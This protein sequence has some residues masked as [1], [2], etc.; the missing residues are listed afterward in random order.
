MKQKAFLCSAVPATR[1]IFARHSLKAEFLSAEAGEAAFI[2]KAARHIRQDVF[3][4]YPYCRFGKQDEL[5]KRL[6]ER[7][8][9]PQQISEALAKAWLHERDE[10]LLPVK[11][12]WR[13]RVLSADGLSIMLAIVLSWVTVFELFLYGRRQFPDETAILLWLAPLVIFF[14]G[15]FGYT[16]FRLIRMVMRVISKPRPGLHKP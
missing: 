13:D 6:L 7:G 16:Y 1:I 8:Y 9:T 5:L 10:F 11:S 14:A 4:G 2:E 12:L 3:A 15:V